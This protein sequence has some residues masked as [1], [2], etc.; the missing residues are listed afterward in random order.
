MLNPPGLPSLYETLAAEAK[1][2]TPAGLCTPV[3]A[4]TGAR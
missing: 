2:R 1:L 4:T 3:L